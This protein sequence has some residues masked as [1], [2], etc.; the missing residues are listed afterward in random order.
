MIS[1]KKL[2]KIVSIFIVSIVLLMILTVV[3]AKIFEDKLVSF[4]IVQLESKIDAPLSIG[5]VSLIPLFSFPRLSAEINKLYIGDPKSKYNDTL[6]FVNSLKVGLDSWDLIHGIYTIDEMEISG[7]DFDYEVD[8]TGKSNIDFII[9]AFVDTNTMNEGDSITTPIDLSAE[10]LKLKNVHVKYYDSLNNVGSQVVIPEITIKAKAK[11]NIYTGKTKGSFVLSHCILKETKLDQMESCR[12]AFELEYDNNEATI[13]ELSI[14]SEGANLDVEGTFVVGD[15]LKLN[16]IFEAKDLDFDILKKYLPKHLDSLIGDA[17]LSQIES[18]R[19]NMD[20]DYSN[21]AVDIKKLLIE[22]EGIDLEV[23]GNFDINDTLTINANIE[24]L[25]LDFDILKKYIPTKY[26]NEYGIKDIGG[27]MDISAEIVGDYSDSTLLPMVDADVNLKNIKV[28]TV[29][30]PEIDAVNLTAHIST[31]EK[32]DMSEA[33]IN[34]SNFEIVSGSNKLHVEGN[35]IGL[36]NTQYSLRSRINVNLLDFENLIPDS[37]A[38]NLQGNIVASVRTSGILPKK[39]N[40]DFLDYALDNTIVS[41]NFRDVGAIFADSLQVESLSTI[42]NYAPQ[43]SGAKELKIDKLNLKSS[44]LNLN[45]KNSS[46]STIISGKVSEPQK[47]SAKLNSLKIQNG[48]S[49]FIGNGEI[50][51]LETPEFDVDANIVLSLDVIISFLPDSLITNMSGT[52]TAKIQ[53]SG[54][55]N[56]DSLDTQLFPI[57]FE[58]SSFNLTLNSVNLAFPDSIMNVDSFSARMGLRNDIL[59]I[60]NLSATYNGLDFSM[61]STVVRNIYKAV[62]LNQKEELYVNSHISLGEFLFDDFE[63]L[64]GLDETTDIDTTSSIKESISESSNI[65]DSRNWT[66]LINGSVSVNRIEIDSTSLEDFN[67]NR[68]H[69]DNL[70]ALFKLTDSSYIVDQFKLNV[71]EGEMNNSFHYKVRDDG[72]QSVSSHNIIQNMNI[73]TMLRDMD[74]FGMDSII[75]Y[76]NISGLFSTDI[77][78]FIPIDDSILIDKMLVSGDITLEKGG[79]Y[80]YAPATEISKFTSIKELDNIQFKTLKSN[81]F[82]FKNKIYVPRTDIVSNALDIAAF[83]M[84][85][86]AGDCEYHLEVHLSNILFGKSKRRIKKQDETGEEVDEKSLKKSSHKIRY[87]I[88]NGKS[89]TRRDTKDDREDMMNKIRV[90]NKMLDFIF[91]P[92]NIHYNTDPK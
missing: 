9:N 46:L 47:M 42:V 61:D 90:Q 17:K 92:K 52:I 85:S 14:S 37:L 64:L 15:T 34:I 89:K 18:L 67:I 75:T 70:S 65:E 40:N 44:T 79:V 12:V 76:E 36:E 32:Y 33:N 78:T 84:Q 39:I 56:P 23:V 73:H 8:S 2:L 35:I 91:F 41:L 53:S 74:N 30:Y 55:I 48:K 16:T 22:S 88:I 20:L 62:L 13:K 29:D 11:N 87:E 72:T 21:N 1:L 26:Y 50:R 66:Y 58:N 59:T 80:N 83:G 51:N 7:L 54:K 24:A 69:I 49:Q 38:K 43:G 28:Q 77:N 25:S 19:I 45:L 63:H 31:G 71:F 6:F 81:I 27:N 10:K 60:D 3:V 68:L 5:K 82:M 4:T 57:L 86:M